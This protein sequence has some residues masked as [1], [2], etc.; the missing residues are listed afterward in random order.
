[1]Y[2]IGLSR[3]VSDNPAALKEHMFMKISIKTVSAH[4]FTTFLSV[5]EDFGYS[6]VQLDIYSGEYIFMYNILISPRNGISV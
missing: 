5:H 1:M 4:Y 3:N 2:S 6:N